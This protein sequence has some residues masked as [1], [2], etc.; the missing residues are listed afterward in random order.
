M[1]RS[2]HR[3]KGSAG[4]C[5]RGRRPSRA[6]EPGL[7]PEQLESRRLLATLYWDPDRI[8]GN[9]MVGTGAGLGGSGTWSDGGAAVWFDPGMN[10]GAGGHVA[11]SSSRGDTAVFAGPSG[12]SVTIAGSLSAAGV[13]FRGGGYVVGG[14][15]FATPAGGTAFTAIAA[16]TFNAAVSGIGGITKGGAGTL[17]LGAACHAYT[18]DTIVTAGTL[19]VLGTIASHVKKSSGDVQGVMFY[20]PQ[21]AAAVREALAVDPAAVL[22]P[23]LLAQSP[24]LKSLTLDGNRVSDLTGVANL[25][26]LESLALIPGDMASAADGLVS[27]APLAGLG[28]LSSLAVQHVGLT[29][30]VLGTLPVLPVLTT[31][32][33]RCN[34]LSAVSA[35]VAAQPR[36]STLLVHGNPSL[37][38]SPRTGLA[39]LRGRAIDVDVASD[40]PEA[41]V[42]VADLAARLYYLPARMVEYVTNTIVFQPYSGVMKGPLATLQTKAGN[43]WDTNS[44]L[45]G[46]YAAAGIATRYVSGVIEIGTDQ[47]KAYVGARDIAAAGTILAQAGLRVDQ[48]PNHLRHTWLEALVTP[49]GAAQPAWV[50]LDAAWKFRDF[51]PGLPGMLAAVPFSPLESRYLTMPE[52]RQKSAAEYYEAQVAGWLAANRPD[53]TTAD[54]AYD[55]PIIQ[56]SFAT[57]PAALPYAVLSAAADRPAA[58]PASAQHLV[59]IALASGATPLFGVSGVELTLADVAL[60][61]LTIDPNLDAS[62]AARPVLRKDG[63]AIATSSV[64]VAAA[65]YTPLTLSITVA[66]PAGGLSFAR[67]FGRMADRFIAIG[68]D[69][70]QFSE[71]LLVEK[72]AV[73]NAEQLGLANAATVDRERA[74]GGLLDL[75]IASYFAATD[76]DEASLAGLTSAVPDRS[77]VAVGIATS[78]PLLSTTAVAGLQFSYLPADLGIDVPANSWGAVAIDGEAAATSAVRDL[79]LG[80]A[81]SSQEG[82]VIEGLTNLESVSTMK[83]FQLA[84]AAGGLGELVE[85]NAGN[86][87]F[88]NTLLP[89]VR[90]EIR[91]AIVATVTGGIAGVAEYAG[92]GFTALVP[93]NEIVVGTGTA[94]LQ[95]KGVGYTLKAVAND[96]ARAALNGK[97][98][99]YIIHGAVGGQP[100]RSYGGAASRAV[101]PAPVVK[102]TLPANNADNY[103]GDPVNIANG[104]VYHDETDVEI[105]NAG[106]P[107][108]FRRRYDSIH[109]VSGLA[110]GPAAWSDRGMGEGWSFTYADR[111]EIAGDG[112]VTW[113][114]EDGTRLDFRPWVVPLAAPIAGNYI[115]PIGVFGGLTGSSAAGFTWTDF[116]G[117][118]TTFGPA[119]NGS[120]PLA[121]SRDRFGNGVKVDLV[122]GT[123]RLSRVSD[124]K[125]ATRWLSFTYNAESPAHIAAVTDFTGRTWS[126]GYAAGRVATAT[127]PDPAA[128]VAAPV[129]RYAYHA[130]KAR[131]GLLAGVTDPLGNVTSW[132]YYAN[133]RGF[134]VTDAEGNRHSFAYNLHRSQSSFIDERGNASRYAYDDAGNLLERLQPDRTSERFT[135]TYKG[136]RA[137]ATDAYGATEAYAYDAYGK[138]VSFTDRLGRTTSFAYRSGSFRGIETVTALNA[139]SD[140][141]DDVV[142]RFAYDAAG[143]LTSQIDD[144]G[145]GRLNLETRFAAAA[146][147]RG[148]VASSTSPAGFV[149]SFTYDPSGQVLTRTADSAPGVT[150]TERFAY[151]QR[152]NLVSKADGNGNITA[153]GYDA[154][155]RKTSETPPDPDGAGPLPAPAT[156]Y[157]YDAAGNLVMTVLHNGRATRVAFDRMQRAVKTARPDGGYTLTTYDAAGNVATQTDAAGR[158]TRFVSD[159]RNRQVAVVLPDGTT[160]RTRFDGGGRVVAATDRAG[161]TTT[162]TFD[163]LGRRLSETAP[164]PV[165]GGAGPVTRYGY[166]SRG[167]L[168][169][170]TDPLGLQ[171]GDT[172]HTTSYDYDALGRRIRQTQADPDGAGPLARPVTS[173]AYDRDGNLVSVTDPR[174]FTASYGYDQLGRRI[175]STGPDPDGTGPLAAATTLYVYDRAGNLRFEICERRLKSAARGGRKV[176][177]WGWVES[178]LG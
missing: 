135:W 62:G 83:A 93:K 63:Q 112:G 52:W 24:P 155:G 84:A 87:R 72:R 153:F 81:D 45:A 74:V 40:R 44:L 154:L 173:F 32:D 95:W 17:T 128:G 169:Q 111:L 4:W 90:P 110:G 10:A 71:S 36:L 101:V 123:T 54:V 133:R 94:D 68:L 16:A 67:S 69:A 108:A 1:A 41:A 14:G 100:L 144:A 113:F 143:F 127:A 88:V 109:T 9:N 57:L 175:S 156:S 42:S 3:R 15:G 151:D 19:N 76:A 130:D 97:T 18:G 59:R 35:A 38:D 5:P 106:V 58:V 31:L 131:Q 152:G 47:L 77:I 91:Q 116:D 11:W 20:D 124:L 60:S 148:F 22:T 102:P 146:G 30:A 99:G 37:T 172:A 80:C 150:V 126:Y 118:V 117:R 27:L 34:G 33:V 82:L 122:P 92:I 170:V 134:R 79:L 171:A 78:G 140:P 7:G 145:P 53:L 6:V 160:E 177:R 51:R 65:A 104:N 89:G 13:E 64:A 61:R 115:L 164:A 163:R 25:T 73:A 178:T 125:D 29:D 162:F 26:A 142:T 119:V 129:V 105:P 107:L 158:L 176:Q 157:R 46:L 137:S 103:Q 121:A 48:S 136:L 86:A 147:G 75:A 49:P 138:V 167:N 168:A 96:P 98:I 174:G 50:S 28:R 70:N 149:T 56:Q 85:I 166:D 21:V 141:G 165:A 139:P 55:G 159:G 114:T 120:C 39:A 12:G 8:A 161:G 23:A 2:R 66:A 43:D 132:E